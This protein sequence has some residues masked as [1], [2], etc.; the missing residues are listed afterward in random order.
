M[1]PHQTFGQGRP[2]GLY[3]HWPAT[4]TS[5]CMRANSGW[6]KAEQAGYP[7]AYEF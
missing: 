6:D 2:H 4:I 7:G 3:G 5:R 1:S